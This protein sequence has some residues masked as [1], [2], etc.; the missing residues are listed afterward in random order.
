MRISQ[1]KQID[2]YAAIYE[3]MLDLRNE[4][5]LSDAQNEHVKQAANRIWDRQRRVLKLE[6]RTSP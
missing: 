6:G 4:L 5:G 1:D 3:T 2:L